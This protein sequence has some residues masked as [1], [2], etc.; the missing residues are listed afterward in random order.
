VKLKT[1]LTLV[2][3][4]GIGASAS[5]A[6]VTDWGTLGPVASVAYITYK[7]APGA[8]DDVYKFNVAG[9]SD[10]DGYG[11]EFEARSVTMPGATFT[12]FS[13]DYGSAGVTQVGT[14]M[15]FTNTATEHMY[16]ALSSGS[17]YF[18]VLGSSAKAGSGY[19]F[20]AYAN[21]AAPPLAVPEP[22][23][24]ALLIAGIGVMTFLSRRR[25]QQ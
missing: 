12:L 9:T 5:A 7:D 21:D 10:I 17:Y 18:E 4:A 8:I 1:A 6:N 24:A 13:G 11:E 14:P 19:D 20:E 23:N 15:S 22:A 2:A 25:R 3:L 16:A